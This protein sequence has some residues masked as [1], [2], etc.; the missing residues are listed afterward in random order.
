[1]T[2][3][4]V[5]LMAAGVAAASCASSKPAT[6]A[7]ARA[8]AVTL[9]GELAAPEK[10]VGPPD[11]AWQDMTRV[12]RGRYMK[13]VVL[14]AMKELYVA[15]DAKT[16]ADF[17]C[18]TCHG[19]G[20]DDGTYKMPNPKIF[21][22][23]A[24]QEGFGKLARAKPAWVQFMGGKVK[25]KMAALLGLPEFDPAQPNRPAMVCHS[26]HKLETDPR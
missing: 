21:V 6:P 23:P 17:S 26:C 13:A 8:P 15:F 2:M 12:Q 24:T 4:I 14:P 5:V 1:M 18:A 25:P 7:A 10:V 11:V 20:V 22:L 16:F 19:P 9:T 3:R